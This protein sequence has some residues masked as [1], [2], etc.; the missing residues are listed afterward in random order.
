VCAGRFPLD[1]L[2]NFE[3]IRPYRDDEV[4]AVLGRL[5]RDPGIQR[6]VG[7]FSAP[8]LSCL[9]PALVGWRVRQS[10][11]RRT[12]GIASVHDFQRM[13]ESY[14]E[15]VIETTTAGLTVSGLARVPRGVARLYVS[16]HRDIALDSALM[17]YALW[18]D[19]RPTSRIAIGD[20]LLNAGPAGELMRLNKSFVVRRTVKG[21]KAAYAAMALTSKYIRQSLEIGESVWIAQREGRAKDGFDRT[22]PALVKMLTLAYRDDADALPRMLER[23]AIVPVSV[24]YELD[25]CDLMKARELR[26][27]EQ[28]GAYAKAPGEDL[29]SIVAGI[30]GDK[31]RVHLRFGTPIA[32]PFEDADALA[33]RLDHDIVTGLTLFP[34]HVVSATR[35]GMD[36]PHAKTPPPLPAVSASFD[37]RIAGCPEADR[38]YLLRQY[39]NPV[40]NQCEV[41]MRA[42][43][44]GAAV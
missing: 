12:K 42:G 18:K 35:L 40:R 7:Q 19:G 43:A 41:A 30:S 3:D 15:R 33:V 28:S 14:V 6:A 38:P 5:V 32:G 2:D 17:N 20:N 44:N 22:D 26:I 13:L 21:T 24:S 8:R 36:T 11:V 9:L 27:R 16:N 25:P 34:T 23:C 39:A 1:R 4:P 37:A 29:A 10:L 31:G